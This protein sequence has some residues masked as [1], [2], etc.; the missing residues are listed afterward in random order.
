MLLCIGIGL[1]IGAVFQ[2]SQGFQAGTQHLGVID[3]LKIAPLFVGMAAEA[4]AIPLIFALLL[5]RK[6]P[7]T[8]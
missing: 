4:W 2:V 3:W 8:Q 7:C 5:I 6:P 1:V